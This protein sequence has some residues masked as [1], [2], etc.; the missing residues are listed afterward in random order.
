V[1]RRR[2]FVF[3]ESVKNRP[4]EAMKKSLTLPHVMM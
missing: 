3:Q 1:K 4:R 2:D